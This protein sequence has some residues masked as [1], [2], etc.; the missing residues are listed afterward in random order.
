MSLPPQGAADLLNSTPWF[1]GRQ[2][3]PTVADDTS[4]GVCPSESLPLD[5]NNQQY[6]I[7]III[8]LTLL[9][10]PVI[11]D[12]TLYFA[13]SYHC[14]S[15]K[16]LLHIGRHPNI[17]GFDYAVVDDSSQVVVGYL[18][19]YVDEGVLVYPHPPD[20]SFKLSWLKQLL[21]VVDDLN[22][23]YG[24]ADADILRNHMLVDLRNNN[25]KLVDLSFVEPI[26]AEG[27]PER[28]Y[29]T[30]LAVD[31]L[32]TG[33]EFNLHP[34]AALNEIESLLRDPPS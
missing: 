20:F 15:D 12:P 14:G 22:L 18:A 26:T 19:K 10:D 31:Q 32:L 2:D 21:K 8:F 33:L 5:Q 28:H 9:I 29:M 30:V 6:N 24:V 25:L 34:S 3:R 23:G 27:G 17:A 4:I 16:I 1:K 11:P 13:S 7:L